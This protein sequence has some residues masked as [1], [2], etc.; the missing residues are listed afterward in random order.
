MR[1]LLDTCVISEL[2]A[3]QP[4]PDV[5]NWI[6][7]LDED[8]VYLS[9]ITIGEIKKGIARL[10]ESRRKETLR[11]WLHDELLIRFHGR[12]LPVNTEV[13]LA[14]G[15]LTASLEAKG[16][17]LPAMDS[18]IAAIALQGQFTLVTRNEADFDETGVPILNPWSL[19]AA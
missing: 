9:A 17:P 16:R 13:M 12:I 7:S 5:V 8:F 6:D 10:P 11:S 3:R 19:S 15:T 2:I 18:L 4:N 14:W 1:Y